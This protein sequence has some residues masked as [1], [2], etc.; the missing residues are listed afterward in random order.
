MAKLLNGEIISADSRQVYKGMDIGSGK[1]TREEMEGI[2]HYLL[3]VAD[4]KDTYTVADFC[5]EANRVIKEIIGRGKLPI[6]CG[7]SAFWIYALIDNLKIPGVGPNDK[8]RAR[9]ST[10][11]TEELFE[12]LK[13]LDPRRTLEIDAKNP[14]RLIRA[15]EIATELGAVPQFEHGSSPYNPIFIGVKISKE[16]LAANIHKRLLDRFDS[17]MIEEVEKLHS[18]GVT[19]DRLEALGLEYRYIARFLQNKITKVEMISELEKA[20]VAFSKRQMTW[21]K[22]DKRIVWLP[23]NEIITYLRSLPLFQ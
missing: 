3:D 16:N 21:F 10:Q 18:Q 17:G 20:I 7:G 15:I 12:T 8:L 22:R 11:T 4:P 14:V 1:V 23:K 2:P 19:W 9:L 6:V 13:Q 5:K